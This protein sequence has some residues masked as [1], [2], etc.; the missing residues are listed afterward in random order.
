VVRS[1][2][3]L[4]NWKGGSILFVIGGLR[5]FLLRLFC[6][7]PSMSSSFRA[8]SGSRTPRRCVVYL[9]LWVRN[10]LMW[11]G[12]L[13]FIKD[14]MIYSQPAGRRPRPTLCSGFMKRAVIP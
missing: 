7:A 14:V 12:D 9:V 1:Q 3:S 4:Q 6:V 2:V 8:G 11:H 13:Y 5:S 10:T